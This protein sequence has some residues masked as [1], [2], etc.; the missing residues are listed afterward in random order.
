MNMVLLVSYVEYMLM[1]TRHS[2][3]FAMRRSVVLLGLTLILLELKLKVQDLGYN[4]PIFT[5]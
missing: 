3:L 5:L 4:P 2:K 1:I